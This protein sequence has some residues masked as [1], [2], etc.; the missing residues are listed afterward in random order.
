MKTEIPDHE[1][2]LNLQLKWKSYFPIMAVPAEGNES[3]LPCCLT[4]SEPK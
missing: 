3:E 4:L 1:N 2:A